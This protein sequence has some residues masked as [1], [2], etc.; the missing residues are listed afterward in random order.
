MLTFFFKPVLMKL[1]KQTFNIACFNYRSRV[2]GSN[3]FQC[4]C[5]LVALHIAVKELINDKMV[6]HGPQVLCSAEGT[7]CTETNISSSLCDLWV[8]KEVLALRFDR[9]DTKTWHLTPAFNFLTVTWYEN[10]KPPCVSPVYSQAGCTATTYSLSF[11]PLWRSSTSKVN[12][13]STFHS[14]LQEYLK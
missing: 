12:K 10:S 1:T 3:K 8:C 5:T 7:V 6:T 2:S 14:L 9:P 13:W 4:W 11:W